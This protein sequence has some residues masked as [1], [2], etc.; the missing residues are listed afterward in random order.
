M[1]KQQLMDIINAELSQH[2]SKELSDVREVLKHVSAQTFRKFWQSL[3]TDETV[4]WKDLT[5]RLQRI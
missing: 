5:R 3:T 1:T 2:P 4:S